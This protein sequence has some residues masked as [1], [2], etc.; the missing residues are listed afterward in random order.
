MLTTTLNFKQSTIVK[1]VLLT[2]LFWGLIGVATPLW[3]KQ[4]F[5]QSSRPE[6]VVANCPSVSFFEFIYAFADDP[7]V[8]RQHTDLHSPV[9][10]GVLTSSGMQKVA[11]SAKNKPNA[12]WPPVMPLAPERKAQGLSLRIDDLADNQAIVIMNSLQ[13][14]HRVVY[15]FQKESC[16]SLVRIDDTSL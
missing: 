13:T 2:P 15:Q 1:S 7:I 12:I 10:G 3:A 16:W 8:Q 6:V 9:L 5:R 4:E 11:Y 14:N